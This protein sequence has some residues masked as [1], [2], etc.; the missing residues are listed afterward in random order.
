MGL[1]F[2]Y[3]YVY[4]IY[5]YCMIV[6]MNL[7]NFHNLMGYIRGGLIFDIYQKVSEISSC[8]MVYN[9]LW[10]FNIAMGNDHL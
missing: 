7:I 6:G 4:I 3:D 2:I 8:R 1:F 5:M 9:T 10:Q